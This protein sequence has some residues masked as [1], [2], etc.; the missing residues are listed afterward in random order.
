MYQALRPNELA[1]L[2]RRARTSGG[3]TPHLYIA[4]DDHR[5]AWHLLRQGN[6]GGIPALPRGQR[7][8]HRWS[9]PDGTSLHVQWH[10][11]YLVAH[12][13]RVDPRRTAFGHVARDTNIVEGALSGAALGAAF[14]GKK[15]PFVGIAVGSLLGIGAAVVLHPGPSSYWR[16]EGCLHLGV[17]ASP[18]SARPVPVAA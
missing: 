10:S 14:G 15:H 8:D 7:V 2:L 13:D 6:S 9:M 5:V 3:S 12:I 11:D 4:Y 1:Y 16:L 17:W 18:C